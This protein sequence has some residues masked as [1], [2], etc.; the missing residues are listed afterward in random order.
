MPIDVTMPKL[1]DSMEEGRIVEWKVGPGERV[2]EGDVLAEIET[3]KAVMELESFWNGT[4]AELL[5]ANGDVAAVGDVIARIAQAGEEA[6]V[7]GRPGEPEPEPGGERPPQPPEPERPRQIR[8]PPAPE[9]EASASAANRQPPREAAPLE[10][11]LPGAHPLSER[12]GKESPRP[13]PP[14]PK[15][16]VGGEKPPPATAPGG[17]RASPR[18]RRLARDRGLDLAQVRGTG[19]E[20]RITTA[21]V[22][23]AAS[24]AAPP[25]PAAGEAELAPVA[26]APGEADVQEVSF[27]QKAAIRRISASARNVPHFYV[28]ATVDAE[29]L[30]ERK[31]AA[32]EGVTLTHLLLRA[33]AQTLERFP[34]ANRSYDRGRWLRWNVV[35]LGL[36]V[37]TDAGLAVGVLRGAQGKDLAWIAQQTRDIVERARAGKLRPEER[38]NATFTLSNLGAY[39]VESFTAII[40]PP[41]ALTLAAGAVREAPVVR[42]GRV[43]AGRVLRLTLSC[44]HRV[45]DGVLAA[46]FLG[47]LQGRLEH[48][49]DL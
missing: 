36:A 14:P 6:S 27:Y 5:R 45:V 46:R 32:G 22:E 7:G 19:P 42:G 10:V 9:G 47:E 16:A 17:V 35:N 44:D 12:G 18:A 29:R 4:V 3:D 13:A 43:E 20:G 31:K 24:K 1:T 26:F 34:D 15:P 8:T 25:A 23:A 39:A 40:N 49:E 38:A 21:D 28:S 48:P 37:Q 41:S 33:A 30:V 11:P 2:R